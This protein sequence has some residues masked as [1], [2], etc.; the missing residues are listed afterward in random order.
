VIALAEIAEQTG[1]TIMAKLR[2][3]AILTHQ[4][5]KLAD[6]YKR[7]FEMQEM[8]RTKN[9]SV[10]LSDGEVNL[11]ILNATNPKEPGH[12]PGLYH[13]GFHIDNAEETTRR[14]NEVYPE[15]A[16]KDRIATYAEGRAS[17]PDGNLIDISTTGW[18][19][20]RRNDL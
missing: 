15:G 1:G 12:K 18:G 4:P 5:E 16:P 8:Y 7:V 2:H 19:L 6:Y 14:I 10:H 3:L 17:D 13:F 11:A 20:L 9:G